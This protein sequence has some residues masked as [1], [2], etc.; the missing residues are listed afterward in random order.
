MWKHEWPDVYVRRDASAEA[1]ARTIQCANDIKLMFIQV[2]TAYAYDTE[3]PGRIRM[4]GH[5]VRLHATRSRSAVVSVQ[6]TRQREFALLSVRLGD[7]T[8]IT[9]S[10]LRDGAK[11]LTPA[12]EFA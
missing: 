4:T 6:R 11:P 5:C 12:K 3:R 10:V 9:V 2:V 7:S 8:A 1:N